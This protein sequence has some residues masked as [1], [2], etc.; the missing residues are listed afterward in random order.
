MGIHDKLKR[1]RPLTVKEAEA[2][3]KEL[4]FYFSH[5]RGSHHH[6][7]NGREIFTLPVHGKDLKKWVTRE[8]RRLYD[9]K[10]NSKKN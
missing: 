1:G 5:A 7:T 2:L 8:L 10:E 4:G 6:W 3:L 9:E